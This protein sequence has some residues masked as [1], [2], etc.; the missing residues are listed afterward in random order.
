MSQPPDDFVRRTRSAT[1]GLTTAHQLSEPVVRQRLDAVSADAVASTVALN[2][3]LIRSLDNIETVATDL[4]PAAPALAV[5]NAMKISPEPFPD[6]APV[7]A[8][9]NEARRAI[10]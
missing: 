10:R 3:A 6:V 4:L 9:P 8:N 5:E 1:A 2:S 7:R